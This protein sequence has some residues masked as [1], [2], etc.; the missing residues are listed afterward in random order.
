MS[1]NIDWRQRLRP[2]WIFVTLAL[3]W[4]VIAG[5]DPSSWIIG[6]PTLVFATWSILTLTRDYLPADRRGLRLRGLL[7]FAPFFVR[8]SVRGGIDVAVRVM[9]PRLRIDPGFQYY[10]V[11]LAD[12]IAQVVFLDS[13]SLL[14]G[15]LSADF[16]DGRI[17]VHALDTSKD[18]APS[19]QRLERLVAALFGEQPDAQRS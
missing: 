19:L 12:P 6:L 2:L 18:L 9:R 7:R 1:G 10:D 13:I 14:P 5:L 16:I 4:L 8:E 11:R 15:T 3:I 17:K